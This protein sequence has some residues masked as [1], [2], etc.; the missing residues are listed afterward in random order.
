MLLQFM[1]AQTRVVAVVNYNELCS[2][3]G[4]DVALM[5]EK[6]WNLQECFEKTTEFL[7]FGFLPVLSGFTQLAIEIKN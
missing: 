1:K 2:S 6:L 3:P 7:S 5:S 4:P